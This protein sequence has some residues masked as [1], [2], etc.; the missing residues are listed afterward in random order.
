M[1]G[2]GSVIGDDV[3][4]SEDLH[5]ILHDARLAD[6]TYAFAKMFEMPKKKIPVGEDST[7]VQ[8][9]WLDVKKNK[10]EMAMLG[11]LLCRNWLEV[12]HEVEL[13]RLNVDGNL[14][15]PEVTPAL[16]AVEN[17]I[18]IRRFL[19]NGTNPTILKKTKCPILLFHHTIANAPQELEDEPPRLAYGS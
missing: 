13:A 14:F 8:F 15:A 18:A 1:K 7:P 2:D 5:F 17:V 19:A 9:Y 10:K 6:L 16:A 11:K 3:F 4:A 12:V